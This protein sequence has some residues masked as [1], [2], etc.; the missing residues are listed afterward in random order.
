[1]GADDRIR[2]SDR[3]PTRAEVDQMRGPVVLEFG[4]EW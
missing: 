4:A 2:S 1:M 3:E